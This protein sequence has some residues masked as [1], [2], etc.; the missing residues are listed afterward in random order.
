MKIFC[1]HIHFFPSIHGMVCICI[2]FCL[3][4]TES[5]NKLLY[6]LLNS[7][8]FG[9]IQII[10]VENVHVPIECYWIELVNN[11]FGIDNAAVSTLLCVIYHLSARKVSS[12]ANEWF[13]PWYDPKRFVKCKKCY[14]KNVGVSSWKFQHNALHS[15]WTCK[16]SIC[17]LACIH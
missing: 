16:F 11:F 15:H 12:N 14:H 7:F 2:L 17:L 3:Q 10:F 5:V 6:S 8:E 9:F 1:K 13:I 4:V